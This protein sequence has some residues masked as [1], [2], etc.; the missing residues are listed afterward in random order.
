M[1]SESSTKRRS[2]IFNLKRINSK[3]A[4]MRELELK[5]GKEGSCRGEACETERF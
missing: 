4:I 1:P 2:V 5:A 3:L